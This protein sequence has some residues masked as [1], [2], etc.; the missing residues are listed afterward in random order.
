MIDK[1]K[2]LGPPD[3]VSLL[4]RRVHIYPATKEGKHA[5]D[6]LIWLCSHYRFVDLKSSTDETDI[7]FHCRA[8]YV[9]IEY[10]PK[11]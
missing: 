5:L 1:P 3:E 4:G 9:E 6:S 2:Y 7:E 11:Y 10:E 8:P